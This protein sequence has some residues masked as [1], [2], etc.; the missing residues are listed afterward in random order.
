MGAREEEWRAQGAATCSRCKQALLFLEGPLCDDCIDK[1]EREDFSLD[2]Y[3]HVRATNNCV[4]NGDFREHSGEQKEERIRPNI[5]R[6]RFAVNLETG[7]FWWPAKMRADTVP[8]FEPVKKPK[9]RARKLV[10]ESA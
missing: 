10:G 3:S 9:K 1:E 4:R 2:R 7:E 6:D 5:A 8:E